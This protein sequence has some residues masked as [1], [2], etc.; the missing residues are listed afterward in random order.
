VIG[1]PTYGYEFRVRQLSGGYTYDLITAVNQDYALALA[2]KKEVTPVRNSAGELSF[3]YWPE[4]LGV[5][6]NILWW[7]DAQAI[8]DKID[9]AKR[10]GVRGVA[11][12]K[13]DGGAD[14]KLW[15]VLRGY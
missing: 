7:S 14:P 15:E 2:S 13:I 1:V 3:S 10:L 12:F 8:K 4:S 9:L 11:I 6:S 5:S